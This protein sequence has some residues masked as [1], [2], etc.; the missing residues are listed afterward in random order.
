METTISYWPLFVL[1]L[2][3]LSVVTMIVVLRLHAFIA[4]LL[5]AIIVGVLSTSLP[6]DG[7]HWV[8]AVESTMTAFGVI[9]GKIAFVIAVASIL[10]VALMESGA[11][12]K[13]VNQL[14]RVFGESK[15]GIALMLAGFILSIP[16]FFDT[17]FFL[18]I[19]LGI[20]LA[21]K[22]KGNFV[23]YVMAIA[24]GAVLTH[25]LVPPTP[26]P[27]VM[28]ETLD[29]NLGT[30]II[31]G[32]LA[33]IL[34][35]IAGYK[36]AQKV[37]AQMT[38]VPPLMSGEETVVNFKKLPSF[39]IS[40]LP[41]LLPLLL[42]IAASISNVISEG[43]ADNLTATIAFLG[44]KNVAMFLGLIVALWLWAKQQNLTLKSLGKQMEKPLEIAGLI[45]LI[46]SA[47]GAFGAMI[48]LSGI[49][50]MIQAMAANGISI[51]LVLVAW[52]MA[53]AIKVAQGSGTVSVI[54]TAGIMAAILQTGVDLPY[55][56]IYIFLS[57]GFGSMTG[58][59]MNDSG[60]WIVG[61]LSGM[62]EKQ[63]LQTWTMLLAVL[64]ITGGIQTLL[65]SYV[66]PLI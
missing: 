51:N 43:Q 26:G 46:T 17:V 23:L 65:L 49:G 54:T 13:I 11:A 27:L 66:L 52:L 48:K 42:I 32:L 2:G 53:A 28:G 25:S 6:G 56:P 50:E 64:G 12:E 16:V 29:I 61:K 10:G 44:N 34:P 60:F 39:F 37:N 45:I 1:L 59:W 21:L 5:S 4:L 20:T 57:I 38:V 55:H 22:M 35:A 8:K 15:A 14:I 9:A 58:S 62:T 7:F 30:V 33:S 40:M 31:A 19:P 36:Y 47:G 24:G 41:I 3:T 18:L 63:T